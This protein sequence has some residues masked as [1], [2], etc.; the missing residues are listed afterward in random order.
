MNAAPASLTVPPVGRS[1]SLVRATTVLFLLAGFVALAAT[2]AG[3]AIVRVGPKLED[4]TIAG[5]YECTAK[6]GCTLSQSTPS[7]TSPVDGTIVGW[8]V[9]GANGVVTLRVLDGNQSTA[10]NAVGVASH[11]N[12]GDHFELGIPIPVA[13]GDR[14]GLDIPTTK[15]TVA[16]F[17]TSSGSKISYW[18]P[19]LGSAETRA[20]K[21][22]LEDVELL[23]SAEVQPAPEIASVSPNSGEVGHSTAV[24]IS[25]HNF[26]GVTG[27]YVDGQPEGFEEVSESTLKA[28]LVGFTAGPATLAVTAKGGS[29]S[30][31]GGFT[32][33]PEPAIPGIPPVVI[34]PIPPLDLGGTRIAEDAEVECHVP[35][36][37]GKK[38]P[39]VK[40]A[41]TAAH[42]KL[43]TVSKRKG[44]GVKHGKVVS[45]LPPAG[46]RAPAGTHVKISLG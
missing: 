15:N 5:H 33:E 22:K 1:P 32:L 17:A 46:S 44:V 16:G 23:L 18:N 42:C 4:E 34:P 27:V 3:A 35:K 45:A 28:E 8:R 26:V 21:E 13:A 38:L 41:L 40:A 29:A 39:A 10:S 31:P 2:P 9:K 37:K 6:E 24:T 12:G 36:L 19:A 14:I 11:P 7:I 25:G 20:P 30:L 43:G